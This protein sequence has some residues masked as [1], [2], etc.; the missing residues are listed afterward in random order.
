[1]HI[2]FTHRFIPIALAAIGVSAFCARAS[3]QQF[4]GGGDAPSFSTT[5]AV[6]LLDHSGEAGGRLIIDTID[7]NGMNSKTTH[8]NA[9]ADPADGF[10]SPD[11][12]GRQGLFRGN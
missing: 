4:V 5:S 2:S 11:P 7:G 1:M 3:A 12:F 6:T 9:S 10:P 8:E